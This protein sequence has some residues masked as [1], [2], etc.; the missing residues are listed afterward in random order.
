MV[1]IKSKSADAAAIILVVGGLDAWTSSGQ[2]IPKA[3]GFH[4]LEMTDV[5]WDAL[6]VIQPDV[7]LC[8][9]MSGRFDAIELAEQLSELGFTGRLRALVTDLPNPQAVSREIRDAC[10]RIDFDILVLEVDVLDETA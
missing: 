6:A 5:T 2:T 1:V 3:D 7:V 10:P 8:P 9:L 4:F